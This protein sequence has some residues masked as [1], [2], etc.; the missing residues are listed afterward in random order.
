MRVNTHTFRLRPGQELRSSIEAYCRE[1]CL[2]SVS[3]VTCVAGVK[4]LS[5]RMAGATPQKQDVRQFKGDYEV[6]SLVGTLANFKSHLHISVSDKAGVVFVGHLKEATV[7]WTAEI[8]ILEDS[9]TEFSRQY[10]PETGFDEL[11]VKTT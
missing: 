3:I 11:V 7:V 1:E 8:T 9:Q 6:V 5:L 2:R 10:D 4:D